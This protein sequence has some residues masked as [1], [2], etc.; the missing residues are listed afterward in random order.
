MR[1]G[2]NSAWWVRTCSATITSNPPN[3]TNQT[4]ATFSFTDT[5]AGVS[6]LCK[7]D[8][9]ALSACTSP[10]TYTGP[11]TQG[12]HVFSVKAEDA[13][14]NKSSVSYTWTINTTPPP[15]PTITSN[16]ANPTNQTSASFSFSDT[17]AGV[18][19]LCQLDGSAFSACSSGK[20]YSGLSQASHTFAVE[21]QD[22]AG[23]QS[24]ATSFTWTIN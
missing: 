3:P 2:R 24:S 18:K 9:S 5:E 17:Q 7:L 22:K 10:V 12:T 16:P 4:S 20:T 1:K 13:I 19:F 14:G 11:L 15:A 23:N 8:A 21:A 6:F